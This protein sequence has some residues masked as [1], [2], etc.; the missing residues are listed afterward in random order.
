MYLQ[1]IYLLIIYK[2][3]LFKK[4]CTKEWRALIYSNNSTRQKQ[5]EGETS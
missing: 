2:L 1:Y 5:R 4:D 3:K